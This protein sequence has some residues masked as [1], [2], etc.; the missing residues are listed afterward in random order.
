M[1]A[2]T[3]HFRGSVRRTVVSAV[4]RRVRK[5][6]T[7]TEGVS[8][9]L[10]SRRSRRDGDEVTDEL[11]VRT[12]ALPLLARHSLWAADAAQLAAAL[13]LRD[14]LETP[15]AFVCVDQRL[16][17][18]EETEGVATGPCS[19]RRGPARE[20]ITQLFWQACCGGQEGTANTCSSEARRSLDWMG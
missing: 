20:V 15:P 6:L 5:R 13:L 12:R 10:V 2:R 16:A 17:L 19:V 3:S 4:E 8:F 18:A 14:E 11:A 1:S 9:S 7:R